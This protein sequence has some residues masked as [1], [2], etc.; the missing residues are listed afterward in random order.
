MACRRFDMAREEEVQRV[1]FATTVRHRRTLPPYRLSQLFATTRT[2]GAKLGRSKLAW[3]TVDKPYRRDASLH[4]NT[5]L[6]SVFVCKGD[7]RILLAAPTHHRILLAAP[8][9]HRILLAAP[10]RHHILLAAP[11]R[12]RILLAAPTAQLCPSLIGQ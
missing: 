11:T 2:L 9:R 5:N 4:S 6:R 10:T 7:H 1:A 8:T 3:S 12:H